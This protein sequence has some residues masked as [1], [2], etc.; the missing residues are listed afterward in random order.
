M[1]GFD[2]TADARAAIKAGRMEATVAQQPYEMGKIGVK[3]A[4]AFL[5]GK[6]VEKTTFVP[7]ELL[8]RDNV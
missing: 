2:G 4:A 6:P 5:N 1:V 7:V 8:T 3:T